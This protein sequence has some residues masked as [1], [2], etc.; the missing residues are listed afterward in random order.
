MDYNV[1]QYIKPPK[2]KEPDRIRLFSLYIVLSQETAP[3][4]APRVAPRVAAVFYDQFQYL[5]H[6]IVLLF[7]L[8]T[9]YLLLTPLL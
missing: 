6:F 4:I 8:I 7:L 9:F 2:R 3:R 5:F 1:H